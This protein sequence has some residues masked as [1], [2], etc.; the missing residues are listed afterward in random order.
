MTM[1]RCL[2]ARFR[3]GFFGLLALGLW[4]N[5]L[6][7]VGYM[8][9]PGSDGWLAVTPCPQTHP[10]AGYAQQTAT[11]SHAPIDHTHVHHNHGTDGSDDTSSSTSSKPCAFGGAT[12]LATGSVDPGLLIISIAFALLLALAPRAFPRQ[13]K[14]ARL[15]PPLR[16]PP[17]LS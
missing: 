4:L 5:T 10:L 2:L 16:G 12:K 8:V 13:T 14:P 6:A 17:L 11:P 3:L 1:L 15:R 9:A 7:P